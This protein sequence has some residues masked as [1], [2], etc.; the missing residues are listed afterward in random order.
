MNQLSFFDAPPAADTD[1]KWTRPDT[2][3]H[4]AGYCLECDRGVWL[5]QI[6]AKHTDATIRNFRYMEYNKCPTCNAWLIP[7]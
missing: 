3:G 2:T 4:R 5:S 1:P 7:F 6:Q